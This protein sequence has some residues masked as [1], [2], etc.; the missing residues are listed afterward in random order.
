MK[1][2]DVVV[3]GDTNISDWWSNT[4]KPAFEAANPGLSINVVITR[5][6]GGNALVAERVVAALAAKADPK[7]D[8]FE[9]FDPRDVPGAIAAGAFEAI[10]E[11]KVPN[12]ALVNPLGKEIPQAMPYRAS[13]VLLAY[14]GAKIVEADAPKTFEQ[15]VTWIKANP[16]QFIYCRPDKGG[17]GKN[18]VVRAIH[19]ANG[20]DPDLFKPDNFDAAKAK[21]A[22]AP[23]WSMLKDLQASL[24]DGGA[25]PAGNNPTLQLFAG[26]AVSM[27]T[28]W[29]DMAL[30]GIAQGVL[31]ETTK[32]IQLSDLAFSGG[33][34]VSAIP[35]NAAHKDAAFKLADFLLSPAMQEAMIKDFGA[36]PA[37][38]WDKLSPELFDKYKDVVPTSV[39]AFPGGDWSSALNDGWYTE[40]ATNVARAG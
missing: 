25:Y 27:I 11:T 36:F 37:V 9:E 31:P 32:L 40:V 12:Y 38:S 39:P 29:S 15:L 21:A 14:D 5:A 10:D 28:A 24:Y 4:L 35:A 1:V 20:R 8:Y 13:Q 3:D 17:S 30:Q 16:G 7:V 19:E 34:A 6:N 18:F 26:G 23:A 33:F 22:F 2:I